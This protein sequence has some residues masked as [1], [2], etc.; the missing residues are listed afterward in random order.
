MR[1]ITNSELNRPTLSEYIKQEKL[2]I[3]VVADN[4]RSLHNIGAMF[5]TMDAFSL[6]RFF[7]CGISG[8]PPNKEIHKSALGAELSVDWSYYSTTLEAV[9][10]LKN[11]GYIVISVEQVEGAIML[12]KLVIEPKMKYALIFGNE[13]SG[14]AQNIVDI[15]DNC[16]E[17]PQLGI[18]HSLNVSVAG[19][20]VLWHLFNQLT[21]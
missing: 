17:I 2:P 7:L 18:K 16:V 11:Q 1:K 6:E 19:G 21:R 14:V 4:I 15:S 3:T 9:T 10:T 12:D 8:T 20:V 13:V 5:R